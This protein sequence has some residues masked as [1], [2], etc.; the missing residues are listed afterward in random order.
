MTT[1]LE[2]PLADSESG[3][4]IPGSLARPGTVTGTVPAGF[5][6]YAR[7]F[8]PV[9]A[10]LMEWDRDYP[11]PVQSRTMQWRDLAETRGTLAHPLM[12]WNSILAG[13]RNPVWN[14][15]GWQ[16]EDPLVGALAAGCLAEVVRILSSHTDSPSA[17]I[18]GLWEGWGWVSGAAVN[19]TVDSE[20]HTYEEP[21]PPPFHQDTVAGAARL[22]L[23]GRK[24]LLFNADLA[25]FTEPGWHEASGWDVLQSPNLLWP[26]DRAWFLASEIDMDST[27]V[28]GSAALIGQL[29]HS[30]SVEALP[31]PAD[32]D[33]THQGDVL[34]ERPDWQ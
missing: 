25:V 30:G 6:A 28:G 24:Y 11:V 10:R 4:W 21:L 14:E 22:E 17:C 34:N 2:G 18:A 19:V 26:E 5:E 12:Q 33:L 32:G 27:I 29:V 20:G 7:I 3:L 16:Y 1:P 15:P 9:Q 23:P 8:H 31:V 13:Y